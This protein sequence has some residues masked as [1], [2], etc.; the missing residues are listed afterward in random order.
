MPDI[1]MVEYA[2]SYR[3][4]LRRFIIVNIPPSTNREISLPGA[5]SANGRNPETL[6]IYP[7]VKFNKSALFPSFKYQHLRF[8]A[9]G[10]P[11]VNC[12]LWMNLFSTVGKPSKFATFKRYQRSLWSYH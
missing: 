4:T 5:V 8:G 7:A 12:R 9:H 3:F 2:N 10:A 11:Y 6:W 1:S